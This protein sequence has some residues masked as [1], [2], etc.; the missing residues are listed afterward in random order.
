MSA[1]M[2]QRRSDDV[3]Y[4]VKDPRS[5]RKLKNLVLYI[6]AKCADDKYFGTV[7][8]NKIL[9]FSDFLAYASLRAPI[10]GV[11]YLAL[12]AGPAPRPMPNIR[13]EMLTDRQIA[14]EVRIVGGGYTERRIVA[15]AK[16]DLDLFTASEIALVDGIIETLRRKTASD[17]SWMSHNRAWKIARKG[18]GSIPYETIFVSNRTPTEA[19]IARGRELIET[20][21]CP[22]L[23]VRR[24][25]PVSNVLKFALPAL[26]ALVG[27]LAQP[28]QDFVVAHPAVGTVLAGVLTLLGVLVKSPLPTKQ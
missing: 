22:F 9:Y 5:E 11:E 14:E 21:C 18:T 24:Y 19:E 13:E 12:D 4:D 2:K 15:T 20:H 28:V 25:S 27:S 17:V 23:L 16:P 10:T 3:T 26:I 1:T 6:A 7:K 8:L